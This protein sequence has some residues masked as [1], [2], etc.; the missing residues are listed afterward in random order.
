ME[1]DWKKLYNFRLRLGVA[2]WSP[3][4]WREIVRLIYFDLVASGHHGDAHRIGWG[5]VWSAVLLC[6]FNVNFEV[7]KEMAKQTI[8]I[9]SS[10]GIPLWFLRAVK[11]WILFLPRA[12][13]NFINLLLTRFL[14]NDCASKYFLTRFRFMAKCFFWWHFSYHLAFVK[15]RRRM[16]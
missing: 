10:K 11:L 7:S 2:Y 15:R 5:T 12:L 9:A 13:L 6:E 16:H 4:N 14:I 1:E 8:P 3:G